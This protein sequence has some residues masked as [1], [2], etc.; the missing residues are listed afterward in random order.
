MLYLLRIIKLDPNNNTFFVGQFVKSILERS[1]GKLKELEIDNSLSRLSYFYQ[2]YSSLGG[3][4]ASVVA[5][6]INL[7]IRTNNSE[8]ES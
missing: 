7:I 4:Q 2:E 6:K 5:K 8:V 1:E 3:K